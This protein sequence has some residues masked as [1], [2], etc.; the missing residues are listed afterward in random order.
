MKQSAL[1][2]D[3]EVIQPTDQMQKIHG[4][5]DSK[6]PG[7]LQAAQAV[8]DQHQQ[9]DG[10]EEEETIHWVACMD[11]LADQ[12]PFDPVNTRGIDIGQCKRNHPRGC[13]GKPQTIRGRER[14]QQILKRCRPTE[15][16]WGCSAIN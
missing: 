16:P 3:A 1:K 4:P 15:K 14:Y 12:N 8:L 5:L 13:D 7:G 11:H 6:L 9:A 2:Q 10:I